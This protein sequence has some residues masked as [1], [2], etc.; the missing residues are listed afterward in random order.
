[1][2]NLTILIDWTFMEKI[3]GSCAVEMMRMIRF[4]LFASLFFLLGRCFDFEELSIKEQYI[5][6]QHKRLHSRIS[7]ELPLYSG[8]FCDVKEDYVE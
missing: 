5:P 1:M 8:L 6:S 2:D 3:N 7:N 4:C